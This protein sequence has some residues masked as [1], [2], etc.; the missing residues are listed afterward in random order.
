MDYTI[1]NNALSNIILP[2]PEGPPYFRLLHQ[3][4]LRR[5]LVNTLDLGLRHFLAHVAKSPSLLIPYR[6]LGRASFIV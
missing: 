1:R 6:Q 4:T 2:K 3:L 5:I